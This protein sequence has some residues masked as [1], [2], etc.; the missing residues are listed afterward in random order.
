MASKDKMNHLHWFQNVVSQKTL[1][2]FLQQNT[3]YTKEKLFIAKQN[4]N[5]KR[6]TPQTCCI[7]STYKKETHSPRCMPCCVA[8]LRHSG[9]QNVLTRPKA[10][11]WHLCKRII[12]VFWNIHACFMERF[13]ICCTLVLEVFINL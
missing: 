9:V 13:Q 3:A 10:S 5:N 1:T 12:Q 6:S 11:A 8:T 2:T 7:E 4:T